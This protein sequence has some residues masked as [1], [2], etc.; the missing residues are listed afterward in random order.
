MNLSPNFTLDELTASQTAD[1]RGLDNQPT[2]DHLENLKR[3]AAFLEDVRALIGKPLVVTSAY[4]SPEVNAAIGG[5]KSS[6]HMLGCAADFVVR[7]MAPKQVVA[8]LVESNLPFDQVIQEFD[9]WTH[10][11]VPNTASTKPRRQALIIDRSGTRPF[12]I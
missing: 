9:R 4:R 3:L 7:G 10:I 1:R 2:P 5:S 12:K 11:S 6:Q 8:A